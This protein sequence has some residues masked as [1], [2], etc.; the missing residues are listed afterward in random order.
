MHLSDDELNVVYDVL[1]DKVHYGDDEWVYGDSH[2][3]KTLR[4]ALTGITAEAR[5]RGFW[6]AK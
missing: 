4:S 5:N 6:W 2:H 3:A 1:Y